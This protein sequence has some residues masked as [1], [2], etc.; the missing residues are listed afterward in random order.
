MWGGY[1]PT[2]H[3]ET[4]L[5]S[6]F[7]DFV[8]RSQGERALLALVDVLRSG[9]S[10]ESVPNLSWKD[11]RGIHENPLGPPTPPD[12]LPDLPYHLVD[13]ANYIHTDYLGSRTAVHHSSF[14]CPF[15]CNFCAVVAMSNRKWLAQSPERVERT[16]RHLAGK[17]G[18]D[19]L[20][21]TDMDFFVSEARTAE[22]ADRIADLGLHWWGLG[23]VDTLMRYSEETFRKMARSGLKMVFSGAESGSDET[24]ERMNKGG[25]ASTELALELA[26]RMRRHGIVPEYSFV[27]GSP[28]IPRKTPAA[29]SSSSAG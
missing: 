8:V 19:A 7:V 1:F 14:G 13:M 23:R 25:T 10:F 17:Y 29:R 18:V 20:Q 26:R 27:L 12:E 15:A 28:P 24:L 5:R 3:A 4:V 2:Q 21:M 22:I 11:E 9:G 16:A 6:G